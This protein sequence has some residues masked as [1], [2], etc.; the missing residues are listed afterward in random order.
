MNVTKDQIAR[1]AED[2]FGNWHVWVTIS[3]SEARILKFK[4]KPTV[5][6][7]VD[8]ASKIVLGEEK[9][10][11]QLQARLDEIDRQLTDLQTEKAEIQLKLQP[12]EVKN[13]VTNA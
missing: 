2:G 3:P 7:V 6:D 10:V 13:V 1:V 9:P 5:Q 8:A 12:V 4:K 11:D